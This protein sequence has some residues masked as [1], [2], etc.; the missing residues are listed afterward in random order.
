MGLGRWGSWPVGTG[1]AEGSVP[2]LYYSGF[3]IRMPQLN[4][5]HDYDGLLLEVC[6]CGHDLCIGDH[7]AR[8]AV[9]FIK[10]QPDG[11]KLKIGN[12]P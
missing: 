12:Y 5:F 4:T 7:L 11:T 3:K 9:G 10:Q 2:V 8:L 1:W 6:T